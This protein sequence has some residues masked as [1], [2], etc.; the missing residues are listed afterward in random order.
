MRLGR[1]YDV[2]EIYE[3]AVWRVTQCF[4][5]DWDE[6]VPPFPNR[7]RKP[8]S[9]PVVDAE[10]PCIRMTD[11]EMIGIINLARDFNLSKVL[12]P[13]FLACSIVDTFT[14]IS[15]VEDEDG[16][17]HILTTEDITRCIHLHQYLIALEHNKLGNLAL[18]A[19]NVDCETGNCLHQL[20]KMIKDPAHPSFYVLTALAGT[21]VLWPERL[22]HAALPALRLC[23]PCRERVGIKWELLRLAIWE[24]VIP[25]HIINAVFPSNSSTRETSERTTA[26]WSQDMAH[27][28]TS[29]SSD[30]RMPS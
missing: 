10:P 30:T 25:K 11:K 8:S 26:E 18:G 16:N 3:A 5:D 14:L 13:A 19:E 4:P 22:Y 12:R 17:K 29:I 7:F 6:F 1:K 23:D 15:G 9:E 27:V 20:N 24:I 21:M 28:L 2:S